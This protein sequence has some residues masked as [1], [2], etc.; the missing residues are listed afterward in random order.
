MLLYATINHPNKIVCH[1]P[2]KRPEARTCKHPAGLCSAMYMCGSVEVPNPD[3]SAG[4]HVRSRS[5]EVVQLSIPP[6][7]I[8]FQAGEVLQVASGGRLCA[9]P[10]Y[11]RAAAAPAVSRNTFAVFMQ[12]CVTEKMYCPAGTAAAACI[13]RWKPGLTFGE[14]AE[15]T[16]RQY[17]AGGGGGL[18]AAAALSPRA[19][20]V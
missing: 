1:P 18:G 16:V 8:G 6:D 7:H 3:P 4:L 2:Q 17:Y 10:H 12:P 13:G 5:G 14:F 20:H 9:T 19:Q 15:A 11:V